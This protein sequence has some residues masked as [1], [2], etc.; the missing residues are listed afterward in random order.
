M[1]VLGARPALPVQRALDE[2]PSS[3]P[4][5]TRGHTALVVGS[6]D[7]LL[8]GAVPWL[9]AGL[10]AGDVTVLSCAEETAE[11]LRSAVGAPDT[12]LLSD[13]R[14][15]MRGARAPD[16]VIATRRLLDQAAAS[17]TGV[18]R[19]LGTPDFGPAPRTWRE[20]QRYESVV[21][22]LLAGS[23]LDALCVYD[24]RQLSTDVMSSAGYT[25]PHLL[26][27]GVRVP[28]AD[29]LPPAHY[30]ATLPLPREPMED[31]PPLFAVDGAR[32]LA[33]LR[34][35]LAAVLA[36]CVPDRD[37]GTDLHLAVSEIAANAFRHGTPPVAARVWAST[38]RVV[39]TI[40]D[41]GAGF[42]DPLAGFQPA[43]GDDLS[44]GG[45]GLWLARKLWDH[46]DLVNEPDGLTVR[47]S[48]PL[49]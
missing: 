2:A 20:G 35:Q 7:A 31:G 4:A 22:D 49:R 17:H 33:T 12:R 1:S 41:R 3:R 39:C 40:S 48:S 44:Q 38:D 45:M 6:D 9:E 28:S 21:N 13:P 11:L 18:L 32:A 37:Q 27:D 23:P 36:T 24:Q 14:I 26:V 10:A 5:P 34:H 29:Y 30:L 43:H 25:H 42:A 15:A 16:A 19:V 8:A 46:V 47:L